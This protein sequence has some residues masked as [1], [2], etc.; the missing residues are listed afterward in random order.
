MDGANGGADVQAV[1][2][3]REYRGGCLCGAVTYCVTGPLRAVIACHCRQCRKTSGH[4]VAATA[5]RVAA[6]QITPREDAL[7]WYRSSDF[8]RRAFCRHCGASLFWQRD[9]AE[10]ISIM[11][12]T[13]DL[14]TELHTAMHIFTADKGD[15]YTLSESVP[16]YA[17]EADWRPELTAEDATDE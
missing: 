16:C 11:A 13:L 8:A 10:E 7:T 6:L 12:G 15:Y 5:A 17:Q 1:D 14:P 4:F 3:T 9:S 2:V